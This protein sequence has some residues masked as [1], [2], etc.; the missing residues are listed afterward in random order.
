MKRLETS[1]NM[2]L[3]LEEAQLHM[4]STHICF[5]YHIVFS[6]K[7]RLPLIK[8]I[9]RDRL[10]SYVA[11]I[12]KNTNGV[13]LAIG[14]VSDHIHLLFGL[15]AS[16]RIDYLVRD[17]KAGS[18]VFVKK[19]LGLGFSWQKGYGGFTVSPSAIEK[20][21]RYIENQE[22]HHG[23]LSFQDEYVQLLKGEQYPL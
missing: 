9:W 6:T 4:P 19:E 10:Y 3:R 1:K 23:R 7:D 18:C 5:H 14:G 22:K 17:I 21:K 8:A 2:K 15:N 16:R 11:G 13:P 12:I 20:V